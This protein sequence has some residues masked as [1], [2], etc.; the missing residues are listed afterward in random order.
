MKTLLALLISFSVQA[1]EILPD[2]IY[3]GETLEE[4]SLEIA[5]EQ[6]KPGSALIVS[7]HHYFQPHHDKQVSVLK[8]L[9]LMGYK[10]SVGMEFIDYTKQDIVDSFI[11]EQISEEEF[12]NQVWKSDN[13]H[14]YRQQVLFPRQSGGKTVAINSPRWLNRKISRHGFDSLT[15]EDKTYL[16]P[17]FEIGNDTYLERFWQAIGGDHF[18]EEKLMNYFT[19]QSLWDDTMA[20]QTKKHLDAN[21]DEV[22]VIIVGDFH[23]AYGGGLPDRLN[24]RGVDVM[25]F[26]QVNM[27]GLSKAQVKAEVEVH[28]RW[29]SRADFVW[30]SQGKRELRPSNLLNWF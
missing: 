22:L 3:D 11:S 6:V 16:P 9:N 24:A 1:S 5:L 25:T 10:V 13:F 27:S 19:A 30:T 4:L 2:R 14:F 12:R 23:A 21:L 15:E 17:N 20:W 28:E 8:S 18:P 29:G 26:S 7:E